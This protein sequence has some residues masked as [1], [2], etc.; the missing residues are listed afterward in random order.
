MTAVAQD[1]LVKKAHPFDLIDDEVKLNV[2]LP[3]NRTEARAALKNLRGEKDGAVRTVFL[4]HT[5][6]NKTGWVSPKM[7]VYGPRDGRPLIVEVNSGMVHLKVMSGNV[8][9]YADS[10]AGNS[11][12]V[13][14]DAQVQVF[15]NYGR[16]A[17]IT[18]T[19]SS[20]VIVHKGEESWGHH[21]AY[22]DATLAYAQ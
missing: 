4:R 9:I 8:L 17:T 18:A 7:E 16:K 3:Q 14:G 19:D 5:A 13:H 11:I 6:V 1:A 10:S 15:V 21:S 12:Y 2:R 20:S 22:E